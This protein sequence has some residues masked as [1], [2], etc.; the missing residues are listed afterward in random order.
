MAGDLV[1][2]SFWEHH[3][4]KLILTFALL[5]RSQVQQLAVMVDENNADVSAWRQP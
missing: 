1:P 3:H 5:R 2:P 4:W